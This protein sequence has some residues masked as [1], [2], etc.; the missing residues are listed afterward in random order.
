MRTLLC[1]NS[2][3]VGGSCSVGKHSLCHDAV[4]V[5]SSLDQL[6]QE[7]GGGLGGVCLSGSSVGQTL[8]TDHPR[9][10]YCRAVWRVSADS[11]TT[12]RD[13]MQITASLAS[14]V[15]LLCL[16]RPMLVRA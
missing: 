16:N 1:T 10:M 7:S 8:L 15:K 4:H 2:D 14:V 12:L 11:T 5:Q 6:Q 9:A 13:C 3:S